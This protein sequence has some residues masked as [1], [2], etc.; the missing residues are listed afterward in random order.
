MPIMSPARS[1][2]D[3]SL[4][5]ARMG[6]QPVHAPGTLGHWRMEPN[7]RASRRPPSVAWRLPWWDTEQFG[8]GRCARVVVALQDGHRSSMLVS[9]SGVTACCVEGRE[10][11]REELR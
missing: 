7:L 2:T 9:A 8:G 1:L 3:G 4:A 6:Q 10:L 5:I 11:R